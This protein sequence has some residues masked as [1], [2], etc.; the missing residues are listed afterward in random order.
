MAD[1]ANSNGPKAR[2]RDL[3]RALAGVHKQLIVVLRSEFE[4]AGGQVAGPLQLL[5]LVVSDPHFAWMAP[6]TKLLLEVG[7]G[8]R[9]PDAHSVE[10]L[11][12]DT[13]ALFEP[14]ASDDFAVRY[15]ERLQKD[16][17]L[18]SAHRDLRA[19]LAR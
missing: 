7:D 11:L 3:E 10:A 2:V 9:A 15:A 8:D 4:A 14:A 6:L 13:K 19:V 16:F 1:G 5:E 12:V 18:L 17:D